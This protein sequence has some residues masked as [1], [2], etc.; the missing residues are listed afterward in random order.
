MVQN[1]MFQLLCRMFRI[2]RTTVQ[3][4]DFESAYSKQTWLYSN[5]PWIA[6]VAR[7]AS[8]SFVDSKPS[9]FSWVEPGTGRVRMT[10]HRANLKESQTYT[11]HFGWAMTRLHIAKFEQILEDCQQAEAM[12]MD[13]HL[14]SLDRLDFCMSEVEALCSMAPKDDLL[15]GALQEPLKDILS[16]PRTAET[17]S[18]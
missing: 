6:G 2:Y 7:F 1:H 12:A 10:G 14:N 15:W 5:K 4:R 9:G 13:R 8:C 11:K 3:M 18:N 16:Q 17:F